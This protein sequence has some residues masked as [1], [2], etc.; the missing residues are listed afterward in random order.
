MRSKTY[1][2]PQPPRPWQRAR[3]H[4]TKFFDGQIQ[5]KI[6]YGLYMENQ[7][8]NEAV[9]SKPIHLD[10]TFFMQI[11]KSICKRKDTLYHYSK[12][13]ID[14]LVKFLLDSAR[15]VIIQDDKIICS[16]IA[17]KVYD[18][19]PRTEFIITEIE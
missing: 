12:P 2:I 15:N 17:K 8:D 1:I 5:E 6:A 7:H 18:N 4:G 9:F 11:P 10:V 16:L 13:D 14:N 3:M 19:N